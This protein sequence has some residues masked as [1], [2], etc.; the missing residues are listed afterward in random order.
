MSQVRVLVVEDES[1]VALDIQHRLRAMGY[2][3]AGLALTGPEALDLV[4]RTN[5]DLVLM[6]IRLKGPISGIETAEQLRARRDLPV[7]YLTAYTD[8]ATL[9]RARI[10]EPFGYVVKP[11]EDRELNITIEI[12]LY[13]HKVERQLRENQ[14]ALEAHQNELEQRV[15]ERTAELT[16]VN[17]ALRLEIAA[18]ERAQAERAAAQDDRRRLAQDIHDSVTQSIF[19]MIFTTQSARQN[20]NAEDERAAE[21]LRE[22]E[23]MARQALKDLRL[24]LYQLRSPLLEYEGLVSA[25]RYRLDAVEARAGIKTRL[26]APSEVEL[27][28][29]AEEDA[30]RIAIEALNNSLKHARATEVIVELRP[31][32]EALIISITDNGIGFDESSISRT[33]GLGLAGMQERAARLGGSISVRSARG[34]GTTVI[35]RIDCF[36]E[37]RSVMSLEAEE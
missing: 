12:A 28:A 14:A 3:V 30:Y 23:D 11:F 5:P 29:E 25:L 6:D 26:I 4:E 22:I 7:I 18:R 31:E 17:E 21:A 20:I 36:G 16:R 9:D 32:A 19:S 8:Q 33:G 27:S 10:S 37:Q 24:L 35:L 13:R 2:A 15:F 1:I 34:A